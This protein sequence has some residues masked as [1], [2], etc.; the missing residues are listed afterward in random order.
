MRWVILHNHIASHDEL[1][2]PDSNLGEDI[3]QNDSILISPSWYRPLLLYTLLFPLRNRLEYIAN[4]D[5]VIED[6]TSL[7]L[8]PKPCGCEGPE[9]SV[10]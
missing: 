6:R 9:V 5:R 7:V 10:R 1:I 2:D 4:V 8:V 3:S